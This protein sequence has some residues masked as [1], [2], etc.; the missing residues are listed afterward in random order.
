MSLGDGCYYTV[1]ALQLAGT[2]SGVAKYIGQ[3]PPS[4]ER[5]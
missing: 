2:P 3:Y 5:A 4:Y 1:S